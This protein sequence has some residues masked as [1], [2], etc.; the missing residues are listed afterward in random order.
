MSKTPMTTTKS[1]KQVQVT[2]WLRAA[3]VAAA[4]VIGAGKAGAQ[5]K[6]GNDGRALDANN[7]VG[8]AGSNGERSDNRIGPTGNQIVTGNV[9][10]GREFRGPVGY[11]DSREFRGITARDQSDRFIRNSA[12]ARRSGT[13]LRHRQR[14]TAA[15]WWSRCR[16]TM[17]RPVA[18]PA[19]TPCSRH[20]RAQ[21]SKAA[22]A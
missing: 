9:T 14:F 16:R 22:W 15:V 4:L 8:S 12:G 18:R 19:V 6:S 2:V 11:T 7:R 10:G 17:P 1:Q 13:F 5:Y 3:A 21:T 20:R